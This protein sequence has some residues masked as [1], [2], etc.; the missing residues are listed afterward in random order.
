MYKSTEEIFWKRSEEKNQ[1]AEVW[2]EVNGLRLK[3][4]GDFGYIESLSF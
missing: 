2:F 1:D 3:G 4:S